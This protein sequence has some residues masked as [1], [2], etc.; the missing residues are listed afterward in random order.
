MSGFIFYDVE[1][2]GLNKSFDQ[3]LQFAAI[4]T[5][6]N[7]NELDRISVR[8]RLMPHI[9]P[10]PKALL[11]NGIQPDQLFDQS[12]PSHYSMMREIV[13]KLQ[14]WKPAT[15]L[16]W[17]S[18]RFDEYFLRQAFFHTLHYPFYTNT[19]SNNRTD[20]LII[21]RAAYYTA[22]GSLNVYRKPN[23]QPD[24]TLASVASANGFSDLGMHEAERDVEATLYICRHI[25][26]NAPEAWSE[27][28]RFSRK[29]EALSFLEQNN[30]VGLLSHW[31][32]DD[33]RPPIVMKIGQ[34]RQWASQ[35]YLLDLSYD[36]E[37]LANISD[38]ELQQLI[39]A[40]NSIIFKTIINA[41]PVFSYLEDISPHILREPGNIEIFEARAVAIRGN[42]Q[43]LDKITAILEA[44]SWKPVKSEHIELQLNDGFAPW[45]D[46]NI[47]EHFHNTD[48]H[49]RDEVAARM[50]DNRL[51]H[52]SKRLQF[53]EAREFMEVAELNCIGNEL[54]GRMF[55]APNEKLWRTIP[56]ALAEA[57]QLASEN[58]ESVVLANITAFLEQQA[59]RF[60]SLIS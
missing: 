13:E 32:K 39:D 23:G 59:S 46:W 17:N 54:Y 28:C 36:P 52:L 15:F 51:R 42:Q 45:S 14:E 25:K 22:P 44:T 37:M 2:T 41:A 7:L 12:L 49:K 24:F 18:I 1:T 38:E 27:A 8:C 21:A 60:A 16:G 55:D 4:H 34:N 26:E 48:W 3:I 58:G 40:Q 47:A 20:A 57:N 6:Y 56:M 10:S 5:D 29:D 9:V 35:Q 11:I 53:F 30:V 43:L 33:H 31:S 50:E 19:H